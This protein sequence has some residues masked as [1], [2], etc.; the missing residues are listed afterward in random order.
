MSFS[1]KEI[2]NDEGQRIG[3][4]HFR[5]GTQNWYYT[6][7]DRVIAYDSGDGSGSHD[8]Q[9]TAISDSG[10]TQGGETGYDF[11]VTLPS[12]NPVALLYRVTPPS[13]R[14]YLKVRRM[15]L[16][17]TDAP[18]FWVGTVA[19]L[20]PKNLAGA[21]MVCRS[22]ISNLKRTGLRLTWQRQCPHALYDRQCRVDPADWE[23]PYEIASVVGNQ[24]T[25]V[26]AGVGLDQAT[27]F[28]TGGI[29]KWQVATDTYDFRMIEAHTAPLV[30]TLFG[31]GDGLAAAM[32]V[33]LY[34]GC[35]RDV[36]LT[37]CLHF[38][39]LDNYGGHLY[40]PGKSPFDGNPVF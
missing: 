1:D 34:P 12:T 37:G 7:A 4:Y 33:L 38:A 19:N 15:Q 21:V 17:E 8:Y 28:F 40:M 32:D 13:G 9:P 2:S 10:V 26:T 39:N 24:V 29:I 23:Y 27:G 5:W 25:L 20:K 31:R 22:S 11:Q 6:S 30:F 3:L 18:L 16:G 14:V 35:T 36:S